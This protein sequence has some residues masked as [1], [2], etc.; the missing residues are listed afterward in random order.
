MR[1]SKKEIEIIKGTIRQNID[2]STIYLFGSRVNENKRGGDIDIFIIADKIDY[3]TKLKIKA[4][5]HSLLH[6][7]IDIVWH[8][9][10]DRD[11]EKEALKGVIL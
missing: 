5:L 9:D 10:F 6:K 1:L 4:K 3:D 2:N 7:P 8:R 11:I